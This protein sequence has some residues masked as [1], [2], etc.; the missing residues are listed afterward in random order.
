MTQNVT[1]VNQ[2]FYK[3]SFCWQVATKNL[4]KQSGTFNVAPQ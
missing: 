3:L 1:W 2:S 4:R